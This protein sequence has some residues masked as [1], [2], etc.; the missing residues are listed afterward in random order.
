MYSH[1]F[2]RAVAVS[3]CVVACSTR[4]GAQIYIGQT[5]GFTGAAASGGKE[6]TDGANLYFDYQRIWRDW[7]PEDRLVSLHDKF[8]PALA[9]QNARRLVTERGV[10]ACS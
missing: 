10:I 4:C 9:A 1:K 6:I 8:D 2:A 7:R 5:A 3:L